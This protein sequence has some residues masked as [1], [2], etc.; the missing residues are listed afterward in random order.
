MDPKEAEK[1]KKNKEKQDAI[2][3]EVEDAFDNKKKT[4]S[5]G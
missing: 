4:G 5:A 3:K 1:E 2:E